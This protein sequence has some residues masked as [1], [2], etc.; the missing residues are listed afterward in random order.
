MFSHQSLGNFLVTFTLLQ[1]QT[2]SFPPRYQLLNI[3]SGVAASPTFTSHPP[4]PPHTHTPPPHPG[5]RRRY[6]FCQSHFPCAFVTAARV[7]E[8]SIAVSGCKITDVLR[9]GIGWDYLGLSI[10]A[11]SHPPPPPHPP[12]PSHSRLLPSASLSR[13]S[14]INLAALRGWNVFCGRGESLAV[15][16]DEAVGDRSCSYIIKH[17]T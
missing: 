5:D 9:G 8:L 11:Y 2:T 16:A 6:L 10:N 7:Y 3:L 1:G 13:F 17:Y 4:P 15:G 14:P 12:P